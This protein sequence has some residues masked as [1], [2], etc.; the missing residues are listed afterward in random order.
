MPRSGAGARAAAEAA[1]QAGAQAEAGVG[2]GAALRSRLVAH[3]SAKEAE[4]EATAAMNFPLRTKLTR[5]KRT[6]SG[7]LKRF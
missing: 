4:V 5:D 7:P 1:A 2:A 3:P 6:K